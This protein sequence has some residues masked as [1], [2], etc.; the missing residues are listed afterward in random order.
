[1]LETEA[2]ARAC[3]SIHRRILFVIFSPF[4]TNDV[5][6]RKKKKER[7]LRV[8]GLVI[9]SIR[10]SAFIAFCFNSFVAKKSVD[11]VTH[12]TLSRF[13]WKCLHTCINF[14]IVRNSV[15]NESV[16]QTFYSNLRF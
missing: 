3:V 16:S 5:Y 11:S 2:L 10:V 14:E 1:M 15:E 13:L 9:F 8:R 4:G 6:Y 12:T 7:V